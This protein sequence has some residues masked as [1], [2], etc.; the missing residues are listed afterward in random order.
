MAAES[1]RPNRGGGIDRRAVGVGVMD[2]IITAIRTP[3]SRGKGDLVW[4]CPMRV[5]VNLVTSNNRL[6]R[7]MR[8]IRQS[9]SAGGRF[10]SMNLPYPYQKNVVS[11]KSGRWLSAVQPRDNF[12]S[13][14]RSSRSFS[15]ALSCSCRTRSLESPISVAIS[16][17]V[18]TGLFSDFSPKRLNTI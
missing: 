4:Q 10:K 12:S 2:C 14:A 8:E 9:G 3:F 17:R 16:R 15:S 5:K 11:V 1:W 18:R 7:R 6:E 13:G